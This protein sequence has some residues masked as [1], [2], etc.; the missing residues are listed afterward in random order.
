MKGSGLCLALPVL[1]FQVSAFLAEQIYKSVYKI[2]APNISLTPHHTELFPW[3]VC[4]AASWSTDNRIRCKKDKKIGINFELISSD[5][6]VGDN[7]INDTEDDDIL[8][9]RRKMNSVTN[10]LKY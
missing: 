4:G 6:D 2:L 1:L 5:V 7:D 8:L 10:P 3:L 9:K